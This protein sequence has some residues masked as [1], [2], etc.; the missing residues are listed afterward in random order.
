MAL[1]EDGQQGEFWF[2]RKS[3]STTMKRKKTMKTTR[4]MIAS[5]L[6]VFATTSVYAQTVKTEFET[7][8][9][10][11]E[12]VN[13]FPTEETSKLLKKARRSQR[14]IQ[15]YIWAIP[16]ASMADYLYTF[17]GSLGYKMGDFFRINADY[18]DDLRWGI[19]ANGT[20]DYILG[21]IDTDMGPWVIDVPEGPT[22]G[23]INGMWQRPVVDLG[24]PGVNNGNGGKHLI[25]GPD[26]EV[27]EGAI[28]AG[29]NIARSASRFNT[30]VY[31]SFFTKDEEAEA[32]F[33][34]FK[35][36]RY[37]TT[38]PETK[39]INYNDGKVWSTN[40][41]RGMKFWERLKW[42]IDKEPMHERDG[43]FY[44]FLKDLG[45]EKGKPFNPSAEMKDLLKDAVIVGEAMAIDN[46]WN[47][48]LEAKHWMG[49]Q[50]ENAIGVELDQ[51]APTHYQL[52]ERAA[53]FYEALTTSQGM[54]NSTVEGIGSAYLGTAKDA[55]GDY[56]DGS[57]M[58][59]LHV[60]PNVPAGR[61]WSLTLYDPDTRY[62]LI[63]PQRKFEVSSLREETTPYPNEDGSYDIYIG[64]NAPTDPNMAEKN[65]IPT[66]PGKGWF[67]YFRIYG[68][69]NAH[70]NKELLLPD[71]EKANW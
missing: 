25:L 38:P 26:T 69:L 16:I 12:F 53:W 31:R 71:F 66:V 11:L 21:W 41:P 19:T 65:W 61:F 37:G 49:K 3:I 43:F 46:D 13:S 17:T 47:T 40:Q 62:I 67:A 2:W 28:E 52:D 30:L 50:W 18:Y 58:Y 55:D 34:I 29:Y 23:F 7:T 56:L 9:G 22:A 48:E 45:I 1:H 54:K 57:K 70:F 6:V 20:T 35:L 60:P 39:P 64:P 32:H 27:P 24:I 36:Y 5:L 42:I 33:Q 59:R 68:P 44:A 10:K 4:I 51:K 63:N 14:A 15:T 8:V